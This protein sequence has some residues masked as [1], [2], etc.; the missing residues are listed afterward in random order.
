MQHRVCCSDSSLLHSS[1]SSEAA[2]AAGILEVAL[3]VMTLF[4]V[5]QPQYIS[6]SGLQ[7]DRHLPAVQ[8]QPA[9]PQGPFEVR[10]AASV[11]FC[12][13]SPSEYCL[14]GPNESPEPLLG[15]PIRLPRQ[16]AAKPHR[17]PSACAVAT[18]A[19]N[20]KRRCQHRHI[21]SPRARP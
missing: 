10:A 7:L 18:A 5:K 4:L 13:G 12:L 19:N 15:D 16:S 17:Q 14:F 3:L 11:S 6:P 9:V 1:N 21:R 8:E 20:Q 2:A